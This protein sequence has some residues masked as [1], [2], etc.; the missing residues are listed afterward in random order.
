VDSESLVTHHYQCRGAWRPSGGPTGASSRSPP[1]AVSQRAVTCRAASSEGEVLQQRR[2]RPLQA[3][4]ISNRPGPRSP[5]CPATTAGGKKTPPPPDGLRS[6]RLACPPRKNRL[7]HL[8][9]LRVRASTGLGPRR[10]IDHEGLR[11]NNA[12]PEVPANPRIPPQPTTSLCSL[13]RSTL[14]R[15]LPRRKRRRSDQLSQPNARGQ[16]SVTP[17]A[18]AGAAKPCGDATQVRDRQS[19]PREVRR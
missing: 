9:T 6:A 3:S 5:R 8:I 17:R 16:T 15:L 10:S 4:F 2:V 12:P 13:R 7:R 18:R 19:L 14:T 11:R 1:D